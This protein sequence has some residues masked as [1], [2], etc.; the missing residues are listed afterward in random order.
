MPF[1]SFLG[2]NTPQI[3]KKEIFRF[4]HL[5]GVGST[6]EKRGMEVTKIIILV[7]SEKIAEKNYLAS[8][9]IFGILKILGRPFRSGL[10]FWFLSLRFNNL[11]H[12]WLRQ[13]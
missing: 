11:L 13:K 10:L 4:A 3:Q 9:A 12:I 2:Q 8:Q 5:I 6:F 7:I 1:L